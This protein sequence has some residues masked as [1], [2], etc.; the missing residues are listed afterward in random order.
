MALVVNMLI[1]ENEIRSS[2]CYRMPTF[3]SPI[4]A[5][6]EWVFQGMRI[7]GIVRIPEWSEK[8]E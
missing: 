7:R 2:G 8:I 3:F 1:E 5:K 6:Y 4:P